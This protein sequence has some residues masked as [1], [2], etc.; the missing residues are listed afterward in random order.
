VAP[1]LEVIEEAGNERG[2]QIGELEAVRR[3]RASLFG[4]AQQEHEG[5]TIGS[6][7]TRAQG[8]LLQHV[9][10]EELLHQ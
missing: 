2:A 6:H 3:Q 10:T 1:D 9:R 4:I 5:V 7:R 8:P